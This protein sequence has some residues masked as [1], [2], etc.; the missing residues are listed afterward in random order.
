MQICIV[1]T[2]RFCQCISERECLIGV[3]ERRSFFPRV[4]IDRYPLLEI[5][6][7]LNAINQITLLG[8]I[9]NHLIV[10][11]IRVW[12]SGTQRAALV[13]AAHFLASASGSAARELQNERERERRSRAEK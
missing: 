5:N 12:T 1:S 6:A 3:R 9:T 11:K 4:V 13:S 7:D 8:P 10:V 2:L